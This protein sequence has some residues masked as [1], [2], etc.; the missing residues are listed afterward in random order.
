MRKVE[1]NL[2]RFDLDTLRCLAKEIAFLLHL[3]VLLLPEQTLSLLPFLLLLLSSF[4]LWCQK[5]PL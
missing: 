5:V 3:A 1:L 2:V 4:V